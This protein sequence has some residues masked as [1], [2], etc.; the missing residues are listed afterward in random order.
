MLLG[1]RWRAELRGLSPAINTAC[2]TAALHICSVYSQV[3]SLQAD[4]QH[5]KLPSLPTQRSWKRTHQHAGCPPVTSHDFGWQQ[6]TCHSWLAGPRNGR[7]HQVGG[8]CPF[9]GSGPF[10]CSRGFPQTRPPP[11]GKLLRGCGAF[12]EHHSFC[13]QTIYPSTLIYF[14]RLYLAKQIHLNKHSYQN[15]NLLFFYNMK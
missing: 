14:T 5:L 1:Q 15:A 7:L 13:L 4:V 11:D 12:T 2:L 8:G 6:Q 10:C 3:V 9:G